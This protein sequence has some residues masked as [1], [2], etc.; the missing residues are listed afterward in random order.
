MFSSSTAGTLIHDRSIASNSNLRNALQKDLGGRPTTTID[1]TGETVPEHFRRT[2]RDNRSTRFERN[3]L[4][5]HGTGLEAGTKSN[6]DGTVKNELELR[7]ERVK[8]KLIS[9]FGTTKD[10]VAKKKIKYTFRALIRVNV[11]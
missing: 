4:V 6:E 3:D 9:K 10:E 8:K 1:L 5:R 7:R 2:G 11:C